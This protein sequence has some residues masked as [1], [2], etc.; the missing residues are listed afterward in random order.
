MVQKRTLT[1]D[2]NK[3][4]NWYHGLRVYEIVPVWQDNPN[5]PDYYP[6]QFQR[7]D[8][9]RLNFAS[10]QKIPHE[11][12]PLEEWMA[13]PPEERNIFLFEQ[14]VMDNI[15]GY[16]E[17]GRSYSILGY[18]T[19]KR[20][21]RHPVRKKKGWFKVRFTKKGKAKKKVTRIRRR[22]WRRL[23]PIARISLVTYGSVEVETQGKVLR[24]RI[25]YRPKYRRW[26]HEPRQKYLIWKWLHD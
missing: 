17:W 13:L 7:D 14:W 15:G 16:F 21:A 23:V 25:N 12:F 22:K 5:Y 19:R 1:P 20:W 9:V 10:L 3:E 26:G 11:E 4:I 8:G 6:V 2:I 24:G 18:E